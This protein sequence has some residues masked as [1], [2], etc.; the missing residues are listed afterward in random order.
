MCFSFTL[1]SQLADLIRQVAEGQ[2][3]VVKLMSDET[4]QR[5]GVPSYRRLMEK[6][7]RWQG[8]FILLVFN[9]FLGSTP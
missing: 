6:N 8:R 9:Q 3:N 2:W 4:L 1:L 7:V 5:S